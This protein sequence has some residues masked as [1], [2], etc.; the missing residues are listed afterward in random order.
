MRSHDQPDK[1]A[2]NICV[3]LYACYIVFCYGDSWH[4][5]E[6]PSTRVHQSHVSNIQ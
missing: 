2:N 4:A 3:R 5:P 1:F 6:Q